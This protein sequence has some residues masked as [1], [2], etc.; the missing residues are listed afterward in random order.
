[1]DLVYGWKVTLTSNLDRSDTNSRGACMNKDILA[2]LQRRFERQALG[3]FS[4]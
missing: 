2:F 1:M 3:S 4:S